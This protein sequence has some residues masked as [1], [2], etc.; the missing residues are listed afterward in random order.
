MTCSW[1]NRYHDVM[2]PKATTVRLPEALA[3]TAEAVAR[4]RGASVNQVIVDALQSEVKRVRQDE[5][6][7]GL[8]H[9]LVER[10]KEIL[11]RLAE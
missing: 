8:L 1:S 10:D 7:M 3:D 9:S 6:F 2:T 11:D 5:E 4:A